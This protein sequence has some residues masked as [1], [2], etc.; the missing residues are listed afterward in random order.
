[1]AVATEKGIDFDEVRY[2]K[3]P[4]D[5]A[6]L[7]DIAA[8]LEDPVENLVRKDLTQLRRDRLLATFLILGP[9]LEL[10]LVAWATSAATSACG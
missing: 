9:V 7:R 6:T 10:V 5:E 8:K 1:M 4:P 2:L 3:T